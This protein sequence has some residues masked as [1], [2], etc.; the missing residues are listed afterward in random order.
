MRHVLVLILLCAVTQA[1][2]A[3]IAFTPH[4]SE[5]ARMAPGS[6]D[7]FSLNYTR[8]DEIYDQAG[9]KTDLGAPFAGEGNSVDVGL[10]TYK[11]LWIGRPFRDLKVPVLSAREQFCR[12][13]TTLGWQQGDGGIAARGRSFGLTTG[14]SGLG[15]VY[16]LCGVYGLEHRRGALSFNGLFSTTIK[17]P[18]GRYDREALLNQG[19]QYWSTIPQFALHAEWGG[20]LILDATIAWQFN[21]DNDDPAYG[22]LTPTHPADVRNAEM[23]LAWKF[24]ERWFADLGFSWRETV[25][26]NRYDGVDMRTT[27]P[28]QADD[29]C[30]LLGLT[31]QLCSATR[32]FLLQSQP[33]SYADGGVQA[34]LFTVGLNYVYRSSTTLSLR[35]LLPVDGR[36][37]QIDVPFDLHLA[38]PDPQ[39]PGAFLPSPLPVAQTTTTLNGVQEAASVSAS[40]ALELRF[41]ILFWA[42]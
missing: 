1:A 20:R 30:R 2:Q 37:G 11:A 22:G 25:G 34:S 40:P 21:S 6:Y 16:G 41:V 27:E 28:V 14:G 17:F 38:V 31:P 26:G 35:L 19:T 3:G 36:G 23:N 39:R 12:V 29:A 32:V 13:I 4:L 5:Y 8:I 15:D 24:S 7:E 18:L 10:L 9:R 33:G 42:P